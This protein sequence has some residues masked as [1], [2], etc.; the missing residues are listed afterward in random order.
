M[1]SA[2][3]LIPGTGILETAKICGTSTVQRPPG[4]TGRPRAASLCHGTILTPK[5][6]ALLALTHRL[7]ISARASSA[8]CSGG[9]PRPASTTISSLVPQVARVRDTQ[10]QG[11][12]AVVRIVDA[13]NLSAGMGPAARRLRPNLG[14]STKPQCTSWGRH[15][16]ISIHHVE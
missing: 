5:A 14:L 3:S 10:N 15:W 7:F 9:R 2:L 11:G 6:A 4:A 1:R 13:F 8:R 16:T 12:G